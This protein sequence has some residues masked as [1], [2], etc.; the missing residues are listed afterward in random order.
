MKKKGFATSAILYT[1]LLLFLVTLVGILNNLQNKKTVLDQLKVEAIS[2]LDQTNVCDNLN[3][4]I[5]KYKTGGDA[6]AE[7]IN[8]GKTAYVKGELV[9]GTLESTTI[10]TGEVSFYNEYNRKIELGFKPV[11][12]QVTVYY[13]N[14]ARSIHIYDERIGTTPIKIGAD[15]NNTVGLPINNDVIY[16]TGFYLNSGFE[17]T[18]WTLSYVAFKE[19]PKS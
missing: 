10:V 6:T 7:D 11:Y 4:E 3:Q 19:F 14:A 5:Q 13:K 1:M 15:T 17:Y 9:T 2:A 18:G 16:D 8:A 12:V